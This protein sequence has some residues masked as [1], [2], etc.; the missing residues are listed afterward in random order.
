MLK[1]ILVNVSEEETRVAVLEDKV[2]VELYIERSLNQRLVGNIYKG[3]VE[4]VLPGMQAAFVD[5]GLEKN[6]FLYVEDAQ[7]QKNGHEFGERAEHDNRQL[8][9]TDLVKEGQEVLI[10]IAKE[11]IGTKGARVTTHVT[12]PGR[13]LV[14][15]PNVDYIGISRRIEN[16]T[17]RERLRL[18]AEK[19]RP[20]GMGIIV[21]TVAEGTDEE[22]LQK[23]ITMLVKL[24][25]KVQNRA[26]NGSAPNLIHKDLELVQ[27]ILRDL[28]TENVDR[29]IIDSR[30]EYDKVIE[31]LD[32]V[33]PALKSKLELYEQDGLFDQYHIN[34]EILRLVKPKVWLKC[35]GYIV[36]DQTEALTA[37]DVN[38]GKYV[39]STN[40]ADTV[41]KTNLEAAK[42]IARQLRLRNIGGIIIIDFIDM[43]TEE[44]RQQVIQHL[45]QETKKDKT[46]TNV[47]GLTQLGLVEMTRKKVRQGL[48]NVLL[49]ACPYCDG[50]GRILSEE[51]VSIE[52]KNKIYKMAQHIENEVIY[53]EVH[54]TVA[55]VLIGSGGNSLRELEQKTKKQIFI[56]GR[57]HF[58]IEEIN[59][60]AIS[61]IEAIKDLGVPVK[62]GQVLTVKIEKTH[63][64]N[65]SDGIGRINGYILDIEG[66]GDL[67]GESVAVEILKV[68]RTYAKA[69]LAIKDKFDKN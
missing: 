29:L 40:L 15:M 63:V 57:E 7:P 3:K 27:R 16:E 4:N 9:I 43:P 69:K 19:V 36:I 1:E 45:E 49:K 34:E 64:A 11:P 6:S 8:N 56:R 46:K 26:F 60:N 23:D 13:F 5:I 28:F 67:I 35:G 62:E 51:T 66:A 20:A 12:L 32:M 25:K 61:N 17:E 21:R 59:I 42:E 2:L 18:M 68:Y 54:P 14:L 22:D 44:H 55:A 50:K 48:Q 39:G 10:Q 38:T 58:H 31:L 24:W 53:V 41:L 47:L 52:V 65:I 33:T 37:I 30:Y